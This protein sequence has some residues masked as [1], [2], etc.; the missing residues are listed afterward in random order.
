MAVP[1]PAGRATARRQLRRHPRIV[2]LPGLP[3]PLVPGDV[4]GAEAIREPHD[5]RRRPR[6][7]ESRCDRRRGDRSLGAAVRQ[8]DRG[9]LVAAARSGQEMTPVDADGTCDVRETIERELGEGLGVGQCAGELPA[10]LV[11]ELLER[12]LVEAY[13]E[14]A[15]QVRERHDR[16]VG[17][18]HPTEV[19]L[20]EVGENDNLAERDDARDLV[21][22]PLDVAVRLV[23]HVECRR[24]LTR[25]L[26]R[27]L[28]RRSYRFRVPRF[29]SS[30]PAIEEDRAANLG[31]MQWWA[32]LLIS[33]GVFLAIY[34][35]FLAW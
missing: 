9:L 24:K 12:S 27:G 3:A 18:E 11:L 30:H 4:L 20:E 28:A 32:W 2:R 16:V 22:E 1:R 14:G 7:R 35:S 5:D 26:A 29:A 10:E 8:V 25:I 31:R 34:A 6:E 13:T 23:R 21:V 15:G 17:S 19:E 33:L